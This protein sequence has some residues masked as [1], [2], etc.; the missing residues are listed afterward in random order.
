MYCFKSM[1]AMLAHT[2]E[3]KSDD[4]YQRIRIMIC[5]DIMDASR[6]I[7]HLDQLLLTSTTH[8]TCMYMYRFV[9]KAFPDKK[10]LHPKWMADFKE[11]MWKWGHDLSALSS[12]QSQGVYLTTCLKQ[13]CCL[14]VRGCSEQRTGATCVIV[15][16]NTNTHTQTHAHTH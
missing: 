14:T 2:D 6:Y 13:A 9:Q 3:T 10:F 12:N 5:T 8:H 7:L 4:A 15:H 11:H 16:L 1:M